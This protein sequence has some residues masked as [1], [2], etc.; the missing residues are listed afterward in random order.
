M[1]PDVSGFDGSARQARGRMPQT[2][3]HVGA[4]AFGPEEVAVFEE[5]SSA[6]IW[7]KSS[8]SN[9]GPNSCV[10]VRNADGRILVRDSTCPEGDVLAFTAAQWSSFLATTATWV[11]E[12]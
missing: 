3:G 11:A 6:G 5:D 10:E 12:D 7:I 9:D 4:L 8:Y 1:R 2:R